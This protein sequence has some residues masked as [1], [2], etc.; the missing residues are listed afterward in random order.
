MYYLTQEGLQKH[1]FY[2]MIRIAL[3]ILTA[4]GF[5]LLVAYTDVEQNFFQTIGALALYIILH[6]T[7]ASWGAP[8]EVQSDLSAVG[9]TI[10]TGIGI[11]TFFA[12][13]IGNEMIK[14]NFPTVV[15]STNVLYYE[16]IGW[17]SVGF[18]FLRFLIVCVSGHQEEAEEPEI[19]NLIQEQK[20]E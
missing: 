6:F 14:K 11:F 1:S 7:I 15:I 3:N 19:A 20:L 9:S 8:K 16:G 13:L 17:S 18:I 5:S 4:I 2:T 10:G 12:I